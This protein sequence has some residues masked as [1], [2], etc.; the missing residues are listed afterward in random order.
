MYWSGGSVPGQNNVVY[1]DWTAET[2]DTPSRE[3]LQH[4]SDLFAELDGYQ[5][6]SGPAGNLEIYEMYELK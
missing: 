1:I 5:G 6:D 4:P 3:G 2:I